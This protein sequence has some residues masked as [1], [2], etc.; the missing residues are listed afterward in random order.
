MSKGNKQYRNVYTILEKV[1]KGE[2]SG[3]SYY[4]SRYGTGGLFSKLDFYKKDD[5]IKPHMHW[6]D[7]RKLEGVVD[8]AVEDQKLIKQEYDHWA[9]Q[10]SFSRLGD[11]KPDYNAYYEKIKEKYRKIP[12]HML[13]D[14]FKLYY[15][16]T[17]KLEFEDR[18]EKNGMRYKF[19][20]KANNP[21]GKIMS[22]H[23]NLKS[24]VFTR[25][26]MVYY[27]TQ[28]V[29]M[30]YV[31]PDAGNDM[32]NG[33]GDSS[34]MGNDDMNNLMNKMNSPTGQS[35]LDRMMQDAQ[36]T[37]KMLDE[38]IDQE[39]QEQM[40]DQA[41]SYTGNKDAGKLSPDYLRQVAK[42]LDKIRLS[43]GSLKQKIKKLLDKAAST[44][45]AN[46]IVEFEDL[47]N[48]T[49]ISGL[50]E[51]HLLHP[52]LRKIFAEDVMIKT[53]RYAGKIDVYL[54]ISG[55]M[56]S[57]CGINN[58]ENKPISCLDFGK[59]MMAKLKEMDMLND[60]YLFNSRL[61]KY[62]ND[63]LSISMIDT[64]GGTDIDVAVRNIVTTGK[65][66]LVITDAE[67]RCSIYS[68]KAFF[69]GVQGANFR[70]FDS[71]VMEQYAQR[72]Q[73]IIFN[74]TTIENVGPDGRV[75]K[76]KERVF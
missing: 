35:S 38:S 76:P 47:F 4:G 5:L 9:K 72:Q 49:D 37:C 51:Y 70:Y 13:R 34:G 41:N 66:A 59:A 65:N 69:I 31:D 74:G 64:D 18:T 55:S 67:D 25:N 33:L 17:E 53:I 1:K 46:E 61:K 20:E 60:V 7:E 52:K 56:G 2:I 71:S 68:D 16:R 24:S 8:A 75:I 39:L 19:L 6:L 15:N 27:L 54:D 45:S 44:F 10:T 14:I 28:M 40:F 62:R 30:D 48:A 22:E 11:Q 58:A 21:I 3:D 50:D 29:Q 42:N 26:M 23:S 57:G 73:C 32:Q 43:M 36:Q 12:K 63:L